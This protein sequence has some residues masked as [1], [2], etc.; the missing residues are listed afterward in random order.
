MKEEQKEGLL[1]VN[2]PKESS[3]LKS[4]NNPKP[5]EK[6]TCFDRKNNNDAV[7]ISWFIFYI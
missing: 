4:E 5:L 2:Q 3:Q 1:E 7:F 6:R